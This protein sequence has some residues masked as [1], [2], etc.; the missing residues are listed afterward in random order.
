MAE[1]LQNAFLNKRDDDADYKRLRHLIDTAVKYSPTAA[2]II[3]EAATGYCFEDIDSI[4]SYSSWNGLV[5]LN[6][7]YPDEVLLTTLVHECRH[8]RQSDK[9]NFSRYDIRTNLQWN[10]AAEADAMAWQCAAAYEMKDALPG[11]WDK[12]RQSHPAVAL[13]Y[14]SALK[15]TDDQDKALG[16]AFKAWHEDASYVAQYDKN[17]MKS[18]TQFVRKSEKK[19]LLS[20]SIDPEEIAGTICRGNE[21]SYL[22]KGFMT[23][24]QALTVREKD[25]WPAILNLQSAAADRTGMEDLSAEELFTCDIFGKTVSR[26]TDKPVTLAEPMA[27]GNVFAENVPAGKAAAVPSAAPVKPVPSGQTAPV[28]VPRPHPGSSK[29]DLKDRI[30]AMK[31]GRGR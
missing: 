28:S 6:P 19:D 13:S 21:K 10:R 18:L 7:K 12:F 26:R 31:N 8:A 15:N 5:R 20:I 29:A 27:V 16:A 24:E 17:L 2:G 23:S 25:V 4:G 11:V 9:D 14:A 3:D 1:K 22:E 30:M